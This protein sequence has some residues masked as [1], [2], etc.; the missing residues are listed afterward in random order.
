MEHDVSGSTSLWAE[1]LLWLAAIA[2]VLWW[3][4]LVD[5]FWKSG[6]TE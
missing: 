5:R 1:N 3:G 6:E 4:W 2:I